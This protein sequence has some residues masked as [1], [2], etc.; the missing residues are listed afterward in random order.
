M[1]YP[2]DQKERTRQRILDAAA[3]RFR[4]KGYQGAGVAD[5]MKAAGLTVGGFYAHFESKEALLAEAVAESLDASRE[6][7]IGLLGDDLRGRELIEAVARAYLS[8][9]HRDLPADGCPL[10]ALAAD[11]ARASEATR[12]RFEEG[13]GEYVDELVPRLE[14]AGADD[15]ALATVALLVGGVLLSRAVAGEELSNRILRSC[16]RLAVAGL[17]DPSCDDPDEASSP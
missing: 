5:V 10:P 1:R 14:Q 9:A 17:D 8:R 12:A 13:L 3:R 16:R 15:R 11:V 7:W 4:E 6:G 2:T